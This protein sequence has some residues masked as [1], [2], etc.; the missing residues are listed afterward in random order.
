MPSLRLVRSSDQLFIYKKRIMLEQKL[1][2]FIVIPQGRLE[3]NV[4]SERWKSDET[5]VLMSSM[6]SSCHP[7]GAVAVLSLAL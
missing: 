5:L 1:E 7:R 3:N 4:E 6:L 2:S